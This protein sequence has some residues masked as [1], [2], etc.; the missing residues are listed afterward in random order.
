MVKEGDETYFP[1]VSAFDHPKIDSG[2]V[3]IALHPQG[4]V[5][6]ATRALAWVSSLIKKNAS[7]RTKLLLW[8]ILFLNDL[9]TLFYPII[10]EV[11]AKEVF[12]AEDVYR[13]VKG[14]SSFPSQLFLV[15]NI[16]PPLKSRQK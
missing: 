2:Q 12:T 15:P 5:E 14:T 10:Q 1:E 3:H 9:S 16:F 4:S 6:S 8:N 13:K 11:L 7:I